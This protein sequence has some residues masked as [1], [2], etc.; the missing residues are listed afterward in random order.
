MAIKSVRIINR[1]RELVNSSTT[2]VAN[3][4]FRSL[5]EVQQFL[6]GVSDKAKDYT[7]QLNDLEKGF[8]EAAIRGAIFTVAPRAKRE[9]YKP[10]SVKKE[11][12]NFVFDVKKLEKA[13][14]VV[15]EIHDKVE[16]MDAVINNLAL[17]FK[18]VTGSAKLISDAKKVRATLQ[19]QLDKAYRFLTETA[20]KNEPEKF[21]KI[22]T[23]ILD[24]ILKTFSEDYEKYKQTVYVVPAVRNGVD[25]VLFSRY[26]E[27][28]N[29]TN[30]DGTV[31]PKVYLVFNCLLDEFGNQTYS[32]NS[33][34]E[35]SPP[36]KATRGAEFTN[37]ES[38]R[39]K[40]YIEL[41]H[42]NFATMI[43]RVPVPAEGHELKAINWGVPKDWIKSVKVEDNVIDFAFTQKV[44]S[45]NK[46]K[47]IAQVMLDLKTFFSSR[48]KA[49][50]APKPYKIGK[51]FGAEF[52]LT[53]P[54]NNAVKRQ[55]RADAHSLQYLQNKLGLSD[56]QAVGLVKYLNQLA[57]DEGGHL[58]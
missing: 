27:F 36:G 3:F 18:G 32:V 55:M 50:I 13:F 17:N 58:K 52:I 12:P 25:M 56:K 40:A 43:E 28:I 5:E 14:S 31:Y 53:L 9:Q 39:V 24:D 7:K 41:E 11:K 21:S 4:N 45:A 49:S 47:A 23:T 51:N 44:T 57:E 38:G 8:E 29:F 15:D 2:D 20:T 46:D 22:V 37:A 10:G 35:F 6:R 42:H 48:I 33:F 19:G 34:R 30:D 54:D 1:L 16:A 26:V